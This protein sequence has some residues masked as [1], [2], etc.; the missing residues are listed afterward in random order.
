M[1]HFALFERNGPIEVVSSNGC[2]DEKAFWQFGVNHNLVSAIQI[3]YKSALVFGVSE[4]VIVDMP[5]SFDCL[6]E[7]VFRF[8]LGKDVQRVCVFDEMVG[9]RKAIGKTLIANFPLVVMAIW[10][11]R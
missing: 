4:N 2:R 1:F 8:F 7:S 5:V 11:W 9:D 10:Q 6:A 3:F